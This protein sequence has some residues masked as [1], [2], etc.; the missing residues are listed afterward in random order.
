MPVSDPANVSPIMAEIDRLQ[1]AGVCE[2]GIGFGKYGVLAREVLDAKH[3]RVRHED[4][5]TPIVGVEGFEGY[6]NPLWV[7]YNE[8]HIKDIREWYSVVLGWPLVLMVDSLEH[9]EKLEAYTILGH[10]VQNNNRVIVSV[11]IGVCPQGAVF[12]NELE[13]HRSSWW[14]EDFGQYNA[15]VLHSGVCHVVSIKGLK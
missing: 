14:P 3:G 9:I 15:K 13:K 10:L 1:P 7:A 2:L 11:P 4:W 12:D 5:K 6:N 8:V